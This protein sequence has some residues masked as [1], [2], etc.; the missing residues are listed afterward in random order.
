MPGR[1]RQAVLFLVVYLSFGARAEQPAEL[2][3]VGNA[4]ASAFGGKLMSAV[5]GM[6]SS[7]VSTSYKE[8]PNDIKAH[9]EL[10][11]DAFPQAALTS[12][13][14][15]DPDFLDIPLA[16]TTLSIYA[17]VPAIKSTINMTTC[18]LARIFDGQL[19]NWKHPDIEKLNPEATNLL[20][21]KTV[22][23]ILVV[24]P[25]K[26]VDS[27]GDPTIEP[28]D[29]MLLKEFLRASC[30]DNDIVNS[31]WKG[32]YV[33]ELVSNPV[34]L[35][36]D[37]LGV[38]KMTTM[39]LTYSSTAKGTASGS[40]VREVAIQ[41]SKGTFI[42]ATKALQKPAN[43]IKAIRDL[44]P[45]PFGSDPFSGKKY[46]TWDM[47]A[48]GV[49]PITMIHY[50]HAPKDVSNPP[51]ST[52]KA[53]A[54]LEAVCKFAVSESGQDFLDGTGLNPLYDTDADGGD[55]L[56]PDADDPSAAWADMIET[57]RGAVEQAVDGMTL[58]QSQ[59][60]YQLEYKGTYAALDPTKESLSENREAWAVSQFEQLDKRVAELEHQMV[61]HQNIVLQGSGSSASAPLLWHLMRSFMASSS[62]P[63]WMYYRAI[64]SAGGQRESTARNNN[65][66]S[67]N[68]FGV[69]DMPLSA[70]DWN[71]ILQDSIV[72]RRGK[73]LQVPIGLAAMS[74]FVTIPEDILP[75][76]KLKMTPCDLTKIF[77]GKTKSWSEFGLPAE[78]VTFFYRVESGTTALITS[79]LS[80]TCPEE[81]SY[82]EK[83]K[84]TIPGFESVEN[85]RLSDTT[86]DLVNKMTA[87]PWSIGYMDAGVG[88][89]TRGLVEVS[90]RVSQANPDADAKF[91]TAREANIAGAASQVLQSGQW[92]DDPR[93]TFAE[94][95]LLNQPG[96]NTWPIVHM[97][98]ILIH[99]NLVQLGAK[100]PL[101][102]AFIKYMLEPEVQLSLRAE[103]VEPLPADV[104]NYLKTRLVPLFMT[105][106]KFPQW[107]Y[108]GDRLEYEG[109]KPFRLSAPDINSDYN[110]MSLQQAKADLAFVLAIAKDTKSLNIRQLV[111]DTASEFKDNLASEKKALEDQIKEYE[112]LAIAGLIFGII[113]AVIALLT[114]AR[115]V[116]RGLDSAKAKTM[117]NSSGTD[118]M[119]GM[120]SGSG[121]KRKPTTEGLD[122]A[123]IKPLTADESGSLPHSLP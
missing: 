22:T 56:F 21:D 29:T 67:W 24:R 89:S 18:L 32:D 73:P 27:N 92:P 42:T 13:E 88:Q 106:P 35:V 78:D 11:P 82:N 119:F 122:D 40:T 114:V 14:A 55:A 38:S 115:S 84:M 23:E 47:E 62:T 43:T 117:R 105:D 9:E 37:P 31:E 79:Y 1:A 74:F 28:A 99:E 44:Y 102:V 83:G 103:R 94:L 48:D 59:D 17:N 113:G 3:I 80:E 85:A 120:G 54:L 58:G 76:G 5:Q 66:E 69:S 50:M 98:F 65:F 107:V 72:A 118:N 60:P 95:N 10:N 108:E 91:L 110:V 49:Y 12:K 123:G 19:T 101:L 109:S 112:S 61:L 90:L 41:N 93:G 121:L 100:G 68:D 2:S 46:H 57:F 16:Y 87:T 116:A 7:P 20:G 75:E 63:V 104:M 45:A 36:D 70:K 51:W 34:A 97:P 71:R 81:W 30:T 33:S 39:S 52:H 4:A 64:G 25:K 96:D 6:A 77:T 26:L 86:M 8:A 53:G 111:N 15:E